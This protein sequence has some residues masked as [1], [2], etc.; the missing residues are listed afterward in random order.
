M[1]TCWY[2]SLVSQMFKV[3]KNMP[4]LTSECSLHHHPHHHLVAGAWAG[5]GRGAKSVAVLPLRLCC[6]PPRFLSLQ[7]RVLVLGIELSCLSSRCFRYIEQIG[8]KVRRQRHALENLKEW[9]IRLV[10]I[11]EKLCHTGVRSAIGLEQRAKFPR[12]C[13]KVL[14]F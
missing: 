10:Y 11:G 7:Y 3:R 1:V 14:V 6:S 4:T 5:Y 9:S 2:V 13:A 12:R 8:H